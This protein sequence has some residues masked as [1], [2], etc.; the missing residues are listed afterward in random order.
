MPPLLACVHASTI[1]G[2]MRRERDKTRDGETRKE[3]DAV[4]LTFVFPCDI[5]VNVV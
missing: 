2:L 4:L 3:V 5:F 1:L